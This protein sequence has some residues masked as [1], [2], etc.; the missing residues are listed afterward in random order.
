MGPLCS[1]GLEGI[2]VS[3]GGL[4]RGTIINFCQYV[5]SDV[6]VVARIKRNFCQYRMWT[7]MYSSTGVPMLDHHPLRS[8]KAKN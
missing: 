8:V 7:R 6:I 3:I 5:G 2:S 1:Q 4:R